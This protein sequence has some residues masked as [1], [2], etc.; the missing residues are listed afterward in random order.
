MINE[1]R[2]L[3][4]RSLAL[5]RRTDLDEHA[6]GR[7]QRILDEARLMLREALHHHPGGRYL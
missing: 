5:L 3:I 7:V 2:D 6:T 4:R 1:L